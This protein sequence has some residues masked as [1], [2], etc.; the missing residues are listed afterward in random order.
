VAKLK[1]AFLFLVVAA[2]AHGE[3]TVVSSNSEPGRNS[4][5]HRH[6]SLQER[7]TDKQADV[8]L[9]VFPA[10]S[11]RV[12]IIDNPSGQTLAE[13]IKSA[14]YIAGVNGGYFDPDFAPIGLRINDG[15]TNAPLKRARL[16]TGVLLQSARGI[17]IVRVGE[18]SSK[19]KIVSAIQCGPLLVDRGQRVRGLDDSR[20][21][22]RTFAAIGT[23]SLAAL[24]VC[25][26][27]S[28][29]E[30]SDLLST[31]RLA[32]DFKLQRALN[33]DGGSSSALWFARQNNGEFSIP[34][35][36]PVR[37]FVAI[38]PSR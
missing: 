36:K 23:S 30:L 25:S 31:T 8:D 17:A 29:A 26:E 28:L 10:K 20:M 1:A 19:Q 18:F 6:V 7:A 16:I 38:V 14:E 4:V 9:A 5:V 13:T 37:D 24:A 22:R 27:V 32:N 3:W 34:E 35:Q 21:A 33:L 2:A 12:R 15:K 11:C